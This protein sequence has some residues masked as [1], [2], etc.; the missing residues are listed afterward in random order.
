MNR[1]IATYIEN[2]SPG[3]DPC[4]AVTLMFVHQAISAWEKFCLRVYYLCSIKKPAT[5]FLNLSRYSGIFTNKCYVVL[6]TCTWQYIVNMII[7]AGGHSL[8]IL[9][10]SPQHYVIVF[11]YIYI[12]RSTHLGTLVVLSHIRPSVH[13]LLTF[14]TVYTR[15]IGL[16][17][18]LYLLRRQSDNIK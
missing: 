16:Y 18:Y 17:R 10:R 7:S 8:L 12:Y 2:Y 1:L 14:Q 15:K 3:W 11:I 4:S 13:P 6:S 9:H 5:L